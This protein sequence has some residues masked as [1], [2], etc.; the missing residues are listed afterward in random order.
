M[1]DSTLHTGKYC[2]QMA[3]MEIT[4]CWWPRKS[5]A[6]T[7]SRKTYSFRLMQKFSNIC[8]RICN[9]GIGQSTEEKTSLQYVYS[10]FMPCWLGFAI[11]AFLCSHLQRDL[12]SL[13]IRTQRQPILRLKEVYKE[14]TPFEAQSTTGSRSSRMATIPWKMKEVRGGVGFGRASERSWG[15]SLSDHQRNLSHAWG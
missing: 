4:T 1:N 14:G 13:L 9:W 7:H 10:Q 15:R 2:L 8:N 5:L 6:T 12:P 3:V 11:Q